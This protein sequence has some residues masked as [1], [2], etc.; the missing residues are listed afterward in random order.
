MARP[1]P[2]ERCEHCHDW[3]TVRDPY[4]PPGQDTYEPCPYCQGDPRPTAH[5]KT[6]AALL[7][8]RKSHR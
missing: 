5:H 2:A 6:L 8:G 3:T 1:I 4:A 7:P